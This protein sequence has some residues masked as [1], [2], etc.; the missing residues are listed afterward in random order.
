MQHDLTFTYGPVTLRPLSA[1]DAP[2]FY[3]L[4]DHDSWQ[5]MATP[6]PR[7][8]EEV[9][10]E[11]QS[12][13]DTP[14]TQAWAVIY[15]GQF[16]GRTALYNVVEGL[17]TEVGSTYY[18]PQVRGT[19]VNPICKFLLLQHCF[20]VRGFHRVALRCDSRNRR[21]RRAISRLGA[22]FEGTLRNFRTGAD[23][24]VVDLDYFS[25]TPDEW[26]QVKAN[27]LSRIS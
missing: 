6:V 19:Q 22:T 2:E 13:I 27:L 21:S 12:M 4:V 24:S 14:D 8:V 25:I 15:D 1:D 20:E 26:P 7:S 18:G 11:L 5:G 17:R 16:V 10:R 23:G 9:A 3:A